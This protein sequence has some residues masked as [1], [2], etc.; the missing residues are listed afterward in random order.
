MALCQKKKAM[1]HAHRWLEPYTDALRDKY[2]L[3]LGCGSGI[4]TAAISKLT[5]HFVAGDRAPKANCTNTVLNLD[6]SKPLPFE[7]E[8][9]DTV[10]ASLCLHYFSLEKTKQIIAEITRILRPHG[11][12]VCRLNSYKDTNYG[13]VG[14][15]EIEPGLYNV[16]GEQKRFFKEQQIQELWGQEYSMGVILHKGIDRYQE[17][18]YVYEFKAIK[19]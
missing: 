10:V 14:H 2:V 16:N 1:K 4:D 5:E 12:F 7:N 11:A 17:T 18:K 15:S 19:A 3:E 9:F 13:A 6:H 8:T